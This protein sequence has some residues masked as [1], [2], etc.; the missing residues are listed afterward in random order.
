MSNLQS[1]S[2]SESG[3]AESLT[4]PNDPPATSAV[5]ASGPSEPFATTATPEHA[6]GTTSSSGAPQI[7]LQMDGADGDD[8]EA[9]G[10]SVTNITTKD[11]GSKGPAVHITLL[12]TSGARH[13]YKI[14][15]RYLRKRSVDVEDQ[16]PFNISVYTLKELIWRD[17]RSGK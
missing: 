4:A 15:Q 11:D 7:Q 3:A 2:Q 6:T 16:D 10:P 1:Q 17:W 9:I 12:L 8:S 14:D 5:P 13:P